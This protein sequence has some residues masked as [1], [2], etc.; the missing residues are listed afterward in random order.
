[1]RQRKHTRVPRIIAVKNRPRETPNDTVEFK[2]GLPRRSSTKDLPNREHRV[3]F[4]LDSGVLT[5]RA[6]TVH[7]HPGSPSPSSLVDTATLPRKPIRSCPVPLAMD[8]AMIHASRPGILIQLPLNIQDPRVVK[9][10]TGARKPTQNTTGGWRRR[11][12]RSSGLNTTFGLH[13]SQA[14]QSRRENVPQ[15]EE[16][17]SSKR[18]S[19]AQ[20]G[21]AT[22]N[23][24]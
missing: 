17:E 9:L 1:M 16:K 3:F 10:L 11:S 15:G 21:S 23:R 5:R 12:Q 4:V 24:C 13:G 8:A 2:T 14:K 20:D 6:V 18:A 19:M 22:L 7:P